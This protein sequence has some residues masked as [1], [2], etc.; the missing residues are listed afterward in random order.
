M[1]ILI[2]GGNGYITKS[3]LNNLSYSHDVVSITR[4]DFDLTNR[5]IT[6]K[7][8]D[9]K[10]FDVVIH[11]A[12]VGGSRLKTDNGDTFYQNIQMFYNLLNNKH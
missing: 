9:G 6:N 7:W 1:N 10:W 4:K 3:L 11:T 2:T 8:F 12:V 5:E